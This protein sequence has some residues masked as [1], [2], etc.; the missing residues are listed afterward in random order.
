MKKLFLSISLVVTVPALASAAEGGSENILQINWGLW[1]WTVLTFLVMFALLAKLAFK[2]IAEALIQAKGRGVHVEI[3]LDK[4]N[5]KETY[6]DLGLLLDEGMP[7]RRCG[8]PHD[9]PIQ[10]ARPRVTET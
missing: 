4:S 3:L 7:P 2:P 5:E 8:A 9:S 6:S 1:F 10:A